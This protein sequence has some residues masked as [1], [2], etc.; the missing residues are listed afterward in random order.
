MSHSYYLKGLS[1]PL[2]SQS[3]IESFVELSGLWKTHETLDFYQ[4]FT[5]ANPDDPC[6]HYSVLKHSNRIRASF[7]PPSA[8]ETPTCFLSIVPPEIN[9]KNPEL[10]INQCN[11]A[12]CSEMKCI[13]V[14]QW[15]MFY[16]G[17][18]PPSN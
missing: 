5:P 8:M 1:R 6:I 7:Y 11:C 10:P 15:I 16:D 12:I 3:H 9:D 2:A 4:T 17:D 13:F 18:L 14:I